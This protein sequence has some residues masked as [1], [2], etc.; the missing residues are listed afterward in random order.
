MSYDLN[1]SQEET[2]Q[3]VMDFFERRHDKILISKEPSLV[4]AEFGALFSMIEIENARSQAEAS[5]TKKNGCSHIDFKFDFTKFYVASVIGIA[6]LGM[7]VFG[8]FYWAN[9]IVLSNFSPHAA[10]DPT[11]TLYPLGSLLFILYFVL[12][13]LIEAYSAKRTR[14]KF[15]KEFTKFTKS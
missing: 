12:S 13:I 6:A 7:V 10:G 14:K 3:S 5:I 4:K 9:V 1:S 15:L 8:A 11:A 2:F